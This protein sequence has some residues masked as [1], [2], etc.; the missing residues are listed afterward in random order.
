MTTYLKVKTNKDT[1]V[2]L[3][4]NIAS[5][6]ASSSITLHSAYQSR[7]H[8]YIVGSVAT[9]KE[10]SA[11]TSRTQQ[12]ILNKRIHIPFED[13]GGNMG[14]EILLIE[15]D[16]MEELYSRYDTFELT[17]CQKW[18]PVRFRTS[19]TKVEGE[20]LPTNLVPYHSYIKNANVKE[21]YL[22]GPGPR[23]QTSVV[24]VN[25]TLSDNFKYDD[26]PQDMNVEFITHVLLVKSP[27]K[28]VMFSRDFAY[29]EFLLKSPWKD[30]LSD[31]VHSFIE[32]THK[33]LMKKVSQN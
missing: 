19:T 3:K 9:K 2:L 5:Y 21:G 28:Q 32:G 4:I 17:S 30:V 15:D 24:S 13:R 8:G 1:P 16:I 20:K 26:L 27:L 31:L 25:T 29:S 14:F 23:N 18:I 33:P 22:H 12:L 11:D 10:S 6:N 7:E